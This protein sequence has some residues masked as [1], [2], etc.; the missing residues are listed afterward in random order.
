MTLTSQTIQVLLIEDNPGDARLIREALAEAERNRPATAR[1]N[2]AVAD[3]LSTGLEALA[4][5]NV[6]VILLDLSLPD[7]QG[8]STVVSI[9]A[10][11]PT[12]PIVVMTGL[13]NE[14][15]TTGALRARAQDYLIKGEFDSNLLARAIRYAI[16]RQRA[17]VVLA[18]RERRFRA[19]IENSSDGIVLVNTE[20]NALYASPSISRILGYSTQEI[21]ASGI[22][23]DLVHPDYVDYTL[24]LMAEL[25]R[26]PGKP[27]TGQYRFRH[28]DGSWQWLDIVAQ[29]LLDE[30]SVRA[31]VVN[32]RDITDRVQAE[33][34]LRLSDEILERV[35]ALVLVADSQSQIVYVSPAAKEVLGYEPAEL[36]GER[37][38]DL[39]RSEA[40]ER[41]R[42]KEYVGRAA[43][44][45]SPVSGEPYE[46]TILARGGQPHTIVW[47]DAKGPAGLLIGVGHDIT[48]RKQR[49]REL[50]SIATVSAALRTAANRSEMVPVVLDQVMALMEA[51]GAA[52]ALRDPATREIVIE[53]GRGT[54]EARTGLRR[55]PGQ[56]LTSAVIESGEVYVSPDVRNDPRV[57]QPEL[58]GQSRAGVCAPL[59]AR[60]DTLGALWVARER[61]F[62]PGE[63]RILRA[64]AD[65]VANAL[66][67]AA[68][69]EQT[70][71]R[72][73]RLSALRAIDMA[74]SSSLDLRLTLDV[75]LDQVIHQL[76]V[77][78]ADVLLLNPHAHTLEYAAGR[79]FRSRAVERSSLRLGQ[80]YAGRAALERRLI[81]LPGLAEQEP[82][83]ARA[84]MLAGEGFQAYYGVPLI[85][86]GLVEG[87]LEIF[88]RSPLHPGSDWLD[89]L[90]ALGGQAAIAID[91]TQLFNELQRSN[92]QLSLAYDATIEGWSRALDLRDK[93]TEGHTQRVTEMTLQLAR[94]IKAFSEEEL[95]H[96]RRGALLHD[97]GKMG[98]PDGIL[99]KPGPLTD[100]EWGIMRRHPVFAFDMLSPIA[101][102]RP[103]LDIPY[104]HHEKWDGTGYPRGLKGEQ[105]P[106]AARLF[107]VVDVWDA[108]KS[109]R[110]YRPRWAQTEVREYLQAHSGTH[111]DPQVVEVFLQSLT[112]E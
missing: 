100:A 36:L 45:E 66:Q 92:L 47:Q 46:R 59:V 13:D 32:Y 41:E 104:C 25:L 15:V 40:A 101:Y 62:E 19:L 70:E 95:V 29:N 37:W 42:E 23:L 91:N 80:G 75:L 106:L 6:D 97:I 94:E 78:A 65:I 10:H 28:K 4:Q 64:L 34:K 74:I 21:V 8:V 52:L 27:V 53:L 55:A 5:G 96:P 82:D 63:V 20:G 108:L 68:L 9:T 79:G 85:A 73:Q 26:Q 11:A 50:E 93:E 17:E 24:N 71:Q 76:R 77:D 60:E 30:P 22:R 98:I 57:T 49:E 7:S 61:E 14:T 3:R 67:R 54:W 1:F 12:V 58:I 107:A 2:L 38:W 33:E 89:F 103:A 111:F 86:K 51:A 56:G 35:K 48:E 16:E 69:H 31:I 87:V 72:L 112:G 81:I 18:G 105:I 90:E 44:G 84:A 43:R 102:L 83:L 39:S 109:D 110:P 88:H 99:L